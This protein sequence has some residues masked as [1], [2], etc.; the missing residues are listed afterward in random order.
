MIVSTLKK[1]NKWEDCEE[2]I[3]ELNKIAEAKRMHEYIHNNCR[4][5]AGYSVIDGTPENMEEC[6]AIAFND[7]I[8]KYMTTE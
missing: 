4:A 3:N 1:Q 8:I 7:R 2:L 5:V 6:F